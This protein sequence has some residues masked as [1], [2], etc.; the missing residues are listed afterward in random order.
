MALLLFL[1][2]TYLGNQ[3]PALP[4]HAS[5]IFPKRRFVPLEPDAIFPYSQKHVIRSGHE[6]QYIRVN[7]FLKCMCMA[8]RLVIVPRNNMSGMG[9]IK[10]VR[11]VSSV[12]ALF[13]NGSVLKLAERLSKNL[14]G[15]IARTIRWLAGC[16]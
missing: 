2:K 15:K 8:G 10:R 1:T 11:I 9:K 4:S 6:R 16:Y 13:Y 14:A 5:R 7:G 3:T 12:S